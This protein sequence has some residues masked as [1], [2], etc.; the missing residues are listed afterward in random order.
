MLTV[1]KDTWIDNSILVSKVQEWKDKGYSLD[2]VIN[3]LVLKDY[4]LNGK[5]V[6]IK[7]VISLWNSKEI[8]L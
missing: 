6:S 5:L 4:K 3:T 1:N 7:K 8:E 2:D